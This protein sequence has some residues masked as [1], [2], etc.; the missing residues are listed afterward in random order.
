MP[1]EQYFGPE[2]VEHD[3]G[4]E[5]VRELKAATA[6]IIGTA[7]IHEAHADTAA[8]TPYINKKILVHRRSDIAKYFGPVRDGYSLPQYLDAL[9]DQAGT[10][11]VGVLTVVNVFN[12]DV[13]KTGDDPDPSLV[14]NLDI[15]GAFDAAGVP[16]GLQLAYGNFQSFGWFCKNIAAPGFDG[17]VGVLSEMIVIANRT[18]ARVW[19]DAPLGTTVQQVIEARGS[20]G[21]FNWQLDSKRLNLCWPHMKVVNL[22]DTSATAG[23][24]ID[25]PLSLRMLGRM[26]ST[27]VEFGYHH[28]PSN[29]AIEGTEGPSQEVLYIPG[30]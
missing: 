18:R 24:E 11:G 16:S 6:F 4:G 26:L 28:S 3:V 7:P 1:S 9:F 30:D 22:D 14:T 21:L 8:W 15:I 17:L 27:V 20:G 10:K 5:L 19:T 2:V 25:Q 23:Q 13:H 12:P 29:R